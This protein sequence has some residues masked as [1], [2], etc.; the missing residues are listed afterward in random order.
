MSIQSYRSRTRKIFIFF[1]LAIIVLL[2]I[3]TLIVFQFVS[4]PDNLILLIISFIGFILGIPI[5]LKI[6]VKLAGPVQKR[7]PRCNSIVSHY[8]EICH[9]CGLQLFTRCPKCNSIQDAKAL[10]CTKCGTIFNIENLQLITNY[11]DI[12][13]ETIRPFIQPKIC[14]NCGSKLENWENL[15]FCEYCGAKLV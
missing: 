10:Q 5:I 4:N 11:E 3:I 9:N 13:Q 8:E 14:P 7:C 15:R 1:M 12:E 6:L 2:I